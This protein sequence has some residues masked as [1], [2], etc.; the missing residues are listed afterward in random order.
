M[1]KKKRDD[2]FLGTRDD[3]VQMGCKSLIYDHKIFDETMMRF[4]LLFDGRRIVDELLLDGSP[5]F[6]QFGMSARKV[7]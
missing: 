3:V 2:G 5:I 6:L 4:F 1:Q 7:S